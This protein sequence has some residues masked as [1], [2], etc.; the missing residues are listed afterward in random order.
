MATLE[1]WRLLE[2]CLFVVS[3]D[4]E[5]WTTLDLGEGLHNFIGLGC[6][7]TKEAGQN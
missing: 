3:V 2:S 7:I 5:V 4:T 1:H 6:C